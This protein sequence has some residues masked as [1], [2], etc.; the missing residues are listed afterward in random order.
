MKLDGRTAGE[1]HRDKKLTNHARIRECASI[2][3]K[4]LQEGIDEKPKG[5]AP[6]HITAAYRLLRFEQL[7]SFR[8]VYLL[9]DR[10]RRH[11]EKHGFNVYPA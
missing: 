10:G 11:V 6:A 8:T 9:N 2:L 5:F 4:N 1:R 7:V 3:L